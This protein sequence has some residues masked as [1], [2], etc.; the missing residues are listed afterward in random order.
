P[1]APPPPPAQ[2]PVIPLHG[3]LRRRAHHPPRRRAHHPPRSWVSD[4]DGVAEITGFSS[5]FG[6][7]L[8]FMDTSPSATPGAL[9]LATESVRTARLD[10]L[11]PLKPAD[12]IDLA[13]KL[14]VGWR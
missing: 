4:H 9:P 5:D 11:T 10:S 12:V 7:F 8:P 1:P 3:W 6:S 14:P 13:W 2:P